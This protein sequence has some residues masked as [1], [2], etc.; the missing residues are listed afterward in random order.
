MQRQGRYGSIPL[1]ELKNVQ[2][3]RTLYGD[4]KT[5][6]STIALE[7]ASSEALPTIPVVSD[8]R[9][10]TCGTCRDEFEDVKEQQAHFKSDFHVYNLKRKSKGL[11]CVNLQTF[12]E[13]LLAKSKKDEDPLDLSTDDS[14]SEEEIDLN[15]QRE[16]LQ[17]FT[18]ETM[19]YK[20]YN[21]TFP[22]W[23]E[24]DKSNFNATT[25]MVQELVGNTSY[26]QWA[27]FLFRAG[28][29][30]GAIF[31]K[32]KVIVHKA[33]QRYT[34][35]RKQGGSQSAHDAA[36]G[37]AK[38]AGAQLRR[39]NEMALQQDISELLTQW[40]TELDGCTRIFIGAAKTS[41]GL[42]FDKT[43]L[44]SDDPRIRKVPFGTLR[45]T[46]EEVCRVRSVLGSA[47]FSPFIASAYESKPV[48]PKATKKSKAPAPEIAPVEEEIVEEKP[49]LP[50]PPLILATLAGDIDAVKELLAGGCSPDIEHVD[51]T[52]RTALHIASEANANELIWL[53][54]ENGANPCAFDDHQRVPYFFCSSK[55]ARNTFRRY[56]GTAPEQWDYEKSK[57]PE[58]LTDEVEAARKEKEKEKKK[59]AKE[60]KK[61]QQQQEKLA[62]ESEAIAEAARKERLAKEAACAACGQPSGSQ[63]FLRLTYKYCS[64]KCVNDH[65]RQL[66]AEAAMKRF[67][68]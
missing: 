34:T 57:I 18:D 42:F 8:L 9:G 54:L 29:F 30:A 10:L 7:E 63:P 48:E 58:A 19:L 23:T 32:D 41:R 37:K 44:N 50:T 67:G 52:L 66:M 38:S 15:V 31:Q 60:R 49:Q 62:K 61:A 17:A 46:F 68:N 56:R 27:V 53:L 2:S 3:W 35:R 12:Q 40:K 24:K 13:Y 21:A 22:L 51:G 45:P 4:S 5:E 39:Y 28:R 43:G 33:F 47:S 25:P 36:S 64:T 26:Y 59:R 55:E 14:E 65:K 20:I 1:W 6:P 11:D 16:P